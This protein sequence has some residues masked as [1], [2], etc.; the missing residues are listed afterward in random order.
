MW[1]YIDPGIWTTAPISGTLRLVI[2]VVI[3]RVTFARVLVHPHDCHV[4]S[5]HFAV[6]K[7]RRETE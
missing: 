5:D 1:S 7:V 4:P 2:Q 3:V 6:L